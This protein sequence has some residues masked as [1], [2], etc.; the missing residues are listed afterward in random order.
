MVEF[1]STR[2]KILLPS[3][4]RVKG[5][6]DFSV[7]VSNVTTSSIALKSLKVKGRPIKGVG[8]PDLAQGRKCFTLTIVF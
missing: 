6:C 8:M 2:F 3:A 7:D 5:L 1:I 4:G